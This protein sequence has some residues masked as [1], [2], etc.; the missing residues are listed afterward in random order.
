MQVTR[1][2]Y[3]DPNNLKFENITILGMPHPPTSVSVTH[4]D[5][6]R[7]SKTTTILPNINKYHDGAKEVMFR[8]KINKAILTFFGIV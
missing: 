5:A 6:G 2:G 1:A 3:R 7:H 8:W 4:V